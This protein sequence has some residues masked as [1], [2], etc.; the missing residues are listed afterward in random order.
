MRSLT[1]ESALLARVLF[2]LC[3][4]PACNQKMAVQGKLAPYKPNAFFADHRT[5]RA[6]VPGTVARGELRLDEAF[7]EGKKGGKPVARM[8]VPIPAELLKRGQ[9]RFN[10]YCA[11]CHNETGDGNGM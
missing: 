5:S 9:Q 10:I 1:R 11:P 6:P 8:R 7:Y 3:L 2:I 4:L